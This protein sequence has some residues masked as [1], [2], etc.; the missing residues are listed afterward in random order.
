MKHYK[1]QSVALFLLTGHPH[2]HILDHPSWGL[3][4]I[5]WG[6]HEMKCNLALLFYHQSECVHSPL[7][8]HTHTDPQQVELIFSTC[9]TT[10]DWM[11][12][13]GKQLEG[14]P[15][16][17]SLH[18]QML[19]FKTQLINMR[20]YFIIHTYILMDLSLK[21]IVWHLCDQYEAKARS[22][23]AHISTKTWSRGE[24]R[25]LILS[26]YS[27]KMNESPLCNRYIFNPVKQQPVT[28]TL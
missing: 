16:Y 7:H 22:S 25:S 18:T 10:L 2:T 6:G 28:C 17:C 9:L 21:G 8:T 5:N 26:S 15:L 23:L 3:P 13:L 11:R 4:L 19:H 12:C 24:E 14:F 27:L 20:S 1:A